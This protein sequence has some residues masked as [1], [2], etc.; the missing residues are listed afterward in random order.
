M[1][2]GTCRTDLGQTSL[3]RTELAAHIQFTVYST[4]ILYCL[5]NQTQSFN[6]VQTGIVL[7]S[8]YI[9]IVV[10][11]LLYIHVYMLLVVFH[12]MRALYFPHS[13]AY[14]FNG[15]CFMIRC[16]IYLQPEGEGWRRERGQKDSRPACTPAALAA[17]QQ[18]QLPSRRERT[19]PR[20]QPL[21]HTAGRKARRTAEE[22]KESRLP[23]CPTSPIITWRRKKELHSC[24]LL[25]SILSKRLSCP[26][27]SL[28]NHVF[29]P[30]LDID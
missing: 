15:H 24:P 1:N 22:Y 6:H 16:V 4:Y 19:L 21:Q 10:E 14:L 8:T 23:N 28:P 20:T 3:R 30:T 12:Y 18:H 9:V 29:V 27:V 13:L 17:Q 11:K 25:P 2:L 26:H 7:C 5:Y